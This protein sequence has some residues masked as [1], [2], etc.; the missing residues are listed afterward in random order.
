[1][2]ETAAHLVDHVF[3]RVPLRQWVFSLPKRLRYFLRHDAERVHQVLRVFLGEVE[4]ALLACA[5]GASTGARFGAVSFIHRFGSALNSNL[6]FHCCVIEGLFSTEGER[7]RFHSAQITETAI[8]RVQRHTRR[9]VLRLFARRALLSPEA[10]EAMQD[11]AHGG[12]FSLHAE[13]RVSGNDRAGLERLLRYCARPVFAS[14]G[15][16]WREPDQRLV[17]RL[18]KPRPGGQTLLELTPAEFLDHLALLVPLPRKHRHRY[19]GVLAPNAPLR[20]MVTAYAGLPVSRAAS[21]PTAAAAIAKPAAI[22]GGGKAPS[23]TAYLWAVLLARIYEV[24]PLTCPRCGGEMRLI[25]FVTEAEPVRRILTHL[26]EPTT[27]PPISPA[28]SPPLGETFD[29]DQAPALDP[30]DAEPAPE[31]DFDQTVSW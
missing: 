9:R 5:P 24:L 7:L 16:E 13:V 31:F 8:A 29:W 1:M 14:E 26:G 27:P 15:L 21:L 2:A 18:P 25:A 28:R 20:A 22:T 3:P 12:G 17:Y 19:H 11:W 6:H 4:K 10:A 23:R 30:A